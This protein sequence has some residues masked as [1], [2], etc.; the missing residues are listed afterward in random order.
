MNQL[1]ISEEPGAKLDEASSELSL[2][3]SAQFLEDI[4]YSGALLS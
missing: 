4:G 3:I 1:Q 2:V